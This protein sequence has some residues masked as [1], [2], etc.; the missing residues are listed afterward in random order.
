MWGSKVSLFSEL[1]VSSD[2]EEDEEEGC[3]P[4][5]TATVKIPTC[6]E[7]EVGGFV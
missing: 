3:V 5:S 1:T 7:D 6:E 2:S 4:I